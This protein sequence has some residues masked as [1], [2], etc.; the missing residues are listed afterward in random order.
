MIA[1]LKG[2]VEATGL[3]WLILDVGGVGYKA[4]ASAR[5]L[6]LLPPEGEAAS[7]YVE[8][9][10]REDHIHLYGFIDPAEQDWFLLLT[11]VQGIGGKAALAILSVV[12]PAQLAQVIAAE[13]KTMLT[14]ADGIGPKIAVRVITELKDK[15]AKMTFASVAAPEVGRGKA[16]VSA[17]TGS[18]EEAIS[19]L[20]NLGYQ[21]LEAFQAVH[22]AVQE[23]EGAPL[24]TG[25]VIRLALKGL[26]G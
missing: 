5:T 15:A 23:A 12:D 18:T 11:S 25:E 22:R 2:R 4:F 16:A 14:R 20:V 24:A 3:D 7:L 19:A 17:T 6:R 10:V 9:H 21:R 26:S 8:T 13:D 1:K